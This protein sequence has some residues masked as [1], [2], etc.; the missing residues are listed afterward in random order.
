MKITK[1]GFLSFGDFFYYDGQ[2]YKIS[3]LGN[4]DINNVCCVNQK[5]KRVKWFDVDSE[6]E[7][8]DEQ[9]N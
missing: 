1:L 8:E 6:V 4:K 9:T 7:V 5:T 3:S 2:K